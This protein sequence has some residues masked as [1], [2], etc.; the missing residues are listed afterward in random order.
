MKRFISVL[1]S[2][3]L[4]V[5]VVAVR[6]AEASYLGKFSR[7]Q[8]YT[9]EVQTTSL[10]SVTFLLVTSKGRLD[11]EDVLVFDESNTVP[12]SRAIP[13]NVDR[14]IIK[15]DSSVGSRGLVKVTQGTSRFEITV[16]GHEEVVF[17]VIP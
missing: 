4:V 1:A 10:V 15:L 13:H 14:V 6:P 5:T 3:V 16:E 2:L 8:P 12:Q 7:S 17:D 11:V 9:F